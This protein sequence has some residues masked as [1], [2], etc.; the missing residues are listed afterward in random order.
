MRQIC[1]FPGSRWYHYARAVEELMDAQC[2]G[3][4]F[5]LNDTEKS[6]HLYF[7][8]LGISL[9][10]PS[11][12]ST[13]STVT[14][15]HGPILVE[16]SLILLLILNILHS[17]PLSRPRWWRSPSSSSSSP[18]PPPSPSPPASPP[19]PCSEDNQIKLAVSISKCEKLSATETIRQKQDYDKCQNVT[20]EAFLCFLFQLWS[21]ES[22]Y[23]TWPDD[24]TQ[25]AKQ[26]KRNI[27]HIYVLFDD[28]H[29]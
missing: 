4:T 18:P 27:T 19:R 24:K 23:P 21:L 13:P 29:L 2:R 9:I 20:F 6:I 26:Q 16:V 25:I 15:S 7:T 12:W 3:N 11:R 28:K 17:I 5:L 14:P 10:F 8:F 22:I 1:F